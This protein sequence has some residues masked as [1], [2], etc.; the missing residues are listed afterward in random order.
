V[1]RARRALWH[2]DAQSHRVRPARRVAAGVRSA[3]RQER[4]QRRAA[5]GTAVRN[6]V[7]IIPV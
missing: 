2:R 7:Q 4:A 3:S 6:L 1:R 5:G